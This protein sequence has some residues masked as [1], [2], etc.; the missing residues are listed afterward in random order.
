[1]Y[2]Y[3]S[4]FSDRALRFRSAFTVAVPQVHSLLDAARLLHN[5]QR[6]NEI[7][8]T[9]S[10]N[11]QADEIAAHVTN[12]LVDKFD[13]TFARIWLVEADQAFLR[14]VA[15]SGL[16]TH[17]NGSFARVPMGAFK[18]GKIAQN[19]VPFLSNR[20]PNE[21][22]VKDRQWAL[23]NN[24][25]GFAGYPLMAGDRVLGVLAAFS[26]HSFAPEF[27]EVLQV[28]CMTLTVALDAAR[29]HQANPAVAHNHSARGLSLSDQMARVLG[30][31][32]FTLIGTEPALPTSL[33]Y[34]FLRAAE[35]L[36]GLDCSYCRL[37]YAADNVMLEA[38]ATVPLLSANASNPSE[39]SSPCEEITQINTHFAELNALAQQLGGSLAT[40][41]VM[42][43]QACQLVL[44]MSHQQS[45]RASTP[46]QSMLSSREQQ[47]MQLL[48]EGKR[49]RNIAEEL[50]ISESTVKFHINN[51]LTKLEAKNR[52]QGVYRAAIRGWI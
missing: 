1:M 32:Q 48:A 28:L 27:L 44:E 18:V 38:I 16:Y 46:A 50:F 40:Q 19:R 6:V 45:L 52:Y 36:E 43:G 39:R 20:L 12:A 21:T 25:Q 15:S 31:T 4:T 35:A 47:I 13:C 17:L 9:L 23:E 41:S 5:L 24:I 30:D 33:T 11:L 37:S 2:R 26:H 42:E 22:W 3:K 51:S 29:Q 34:L 8:Q 14:L 7:A 10:G 49:D